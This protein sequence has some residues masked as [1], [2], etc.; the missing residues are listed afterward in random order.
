MESFLWHNTMFK[1]RFSIHICR[2]HAIPILILSRSFA[3][4][5]FVNGK[6][7]YRDHVRIKCIIFSGAFKQ[8]IA[9]N[10]RFA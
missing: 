10:I 7:I 2:L 3:M 4:G 1:E 6:R 9:S 5:L 8:V